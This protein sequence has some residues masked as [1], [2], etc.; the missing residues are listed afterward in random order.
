[1]GRNLPPL[2]AL[3]AFEIASRVASFTAAADELCIS[4]GAVSRHIARLEDHLG[5][6]LFDR[7]GRQVRLTDAGA[8]LA[9]EMHGV[10]DRI[11]AAS[12]RV[13]RIRT[14]QCIRLGLFPTMAASWIMPRLAEFQ[15]THPAIELQVTCKTDFDG[16]DGRRFDVVSGRGPIAGEDVEYQAIL[17][18]ELR[19]VCAPEIVERL[20][21]PEDL[22]HCTTL[23]SMNRRDDWGAWLARAGLPDLDAMRVLRFENS[24]LAH[25]A[26]S[27]GV[28]VAMSIF[29][30][31]AAI[32]SGRLVEPFP[33]TVRTG[34]SYGLLW[35]RSIGRSPSI[36][37]FRDWLKDQVDD[38][39]ARLPS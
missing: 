31:A 10:F 28:G 32:V 15:A 20:R 16:E 6:P 8:L 37:V 23:H 35:P 9:D 22:C 38:R 25:Q 34:E 18:I 17:D 36:R 2:N 1:M 26:A 3:R 27:N 4:Q 24:V 29:R 19:P 14:P 12:R 11:E 33:L 13:S 39:R 5:I 7:K 21:S 30:D